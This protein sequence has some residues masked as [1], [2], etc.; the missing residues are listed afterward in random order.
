MVA[1]KVTPIAYKPKNRKHYKQAI[2]ILNRSTATCAV[3]DCKTLKHIS[4]KDDV[5]SY[6]PLDEMEGCT[7]FKLKL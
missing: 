3:V 7:I 5:E 6:Y 2:M 1:I 4:L